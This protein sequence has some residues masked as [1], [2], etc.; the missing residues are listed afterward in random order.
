MLRQPFL[1]R[2]QKQ[3]RLRARVEREQKLGDFFAG[4]GVEISGRLVGEQNARPRGNRAGQR[5][6]LLF[7][8]GELSRIVIEP[9][10]ETDRFQFGF[11]FGERVAR[12][13]Q[14][15]RHG[16]ILQRRHGRDEMKRL[17]D[18]PNMIA[19]E[20]RE[21]ILPHLGDVRARDG[22][23]ALR[24]RFQSRGDHKKRGLAGTGWAEKGDGLAGRHAERHA[25][26]NVHRPGGA[27][28][29]E[30]YVLQID[31]GGHEASK[32]GP[33]VARSTRA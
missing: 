13:G 17:K 9:F 19:A 11:R 14:F 4:V 1:M 5:H 33:A 29:R 18:D 3:C 32:E 2:D 27:G 7:A 24:G 30:S 28:Q 26:Q 22:D 21:F 12:A 16:D 25:G 31:G 23:A 8:A 15:Q 20:A 10:A 6:A